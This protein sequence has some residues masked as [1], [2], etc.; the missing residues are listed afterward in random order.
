MRILATILF[1][2]T[3]YIF[4]Y[5]LRCLF[6]FLLK[7]DAYTIHVGF[8]WG[9]ETEVRWVEGER[10]RVKVKTREMWLEDFSLSLPR[11]VCSWPWAAP[12]GW[13][14]WRCWL[15]LETRTRIKHTQTH[16]HR[17]SV[18]SARLERNRW[19]MCFQLLLWMPTVD[20]QSHTVMKVKI[21]KLRN[22]QSK[23]I[24]CQ[25]VNCP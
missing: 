14:G 22:P 13:W 2:D 9:Q 25:R 1:F 24:M 5:H 10:D 7:Q 17:R 8:V 18:R 15:I 11:L 3:T 6:F 19:K 20:G 12:A 4:F 16:T 23:W 21:E